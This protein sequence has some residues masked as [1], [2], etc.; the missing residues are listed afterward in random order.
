MASGP[1]L[2]CSRPRRPAPPL[3]TTALKPM[4]HIG[5]KTGEGGPAT[6]STK[7]T[8]VTVEELTGLIT[9]AGMNVLAKREGREKGCAGTL[10]PLSSCGRA[11]WLSFRY[12]DGACSG[13]P[14][15]AAGGR[16]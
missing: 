7:Y 8:F 14:A 13:N 2:A 15:P 12:T 11:K 9:D 10:D 5:M 16:C 3:A 4:A 1:T 6:A